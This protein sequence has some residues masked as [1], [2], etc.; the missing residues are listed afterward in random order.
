MDRGAEHLCKV[1]MLLFNAL[2][3]LLHPSSLVAVRTLTVM[4]VRE[5]L[6][7]RSAL[8]MLSEGTVTLYVH[9][10]AAPEDHEQF[11]ELVRLY[12]HARL[13]GPSGVVQIRV[14]DPSANSPVMRIKRQ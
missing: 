11:V 1:L 5:L 4:R 6:L 7:R 12:N 8:G 13:R 2:S 3:S 10:L 14:R 9:P